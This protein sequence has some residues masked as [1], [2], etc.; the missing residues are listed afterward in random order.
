MSLSDND[1]TTL[2]EDV[3]GNNDDE[4]TVNCVV[5]LEKINFKELIVEQLM[6]YHCSYRNVR[7]MFYTKYGHLRGFP[8]RNNKVVMKVNG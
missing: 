3:E 6:R 8:A 7:F 1:D 2:E 4:I 5:D